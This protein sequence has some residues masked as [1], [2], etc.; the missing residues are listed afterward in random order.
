MEGAGLLKPVVGLAGRHPWWVFVGAFVVRLVLIGYGEWQDRTM[1][2]KYTDIDYMVFTDAARFITEGGSPYDRSTYRYTPL[3][4]WLMTPNIY[5]HPVFGKLLFAA[6]DVA[7]GALIY[8]L[9]PLLNDQ[10]KP[11]IAPAAGKSTTK[12]KSTTT[13][14]TKKAEAVV[15]AGQEEAIV[16]ACVWL[17]NP[18][19]IVISTRGNAE[20]LI[21]LLVVAALYCLLTKRLIL[22]AILYGLSVHFK[23]YP[24]IYALPL[25]LF[26]KYHHQRGHQQ[27]R[28][29]KKQEDTFISAFVD[30]FRITRE[31][32]VFT[33]VSGGTFVLLSL[34]LYAVY[35]FPF[36]YHTYL[37][38]IT[39]TDHR[40]NFSP[41]FY[42]LYLLSSSASS[43]QVEHTLVGDGDGSLVSTL[44]SS[45]LASSRAI[46][47]LAFLPQVVLLLSFSFRYALS[48]AARDLALC[49]FL[50]TF[51]FV[52]FLKVC[53]SQYFIWY[54]SLLPLA[55]YRSSMS[56][57][58]LVFLFALWMGTQA[59]WLS[60][61][62]Y[63]E[64]EGENTFS[65]I[66]LAS[67]AFFGANVWILIQF[68]RHHSAPV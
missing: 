51:T 49:L 66:W 41:Y 65:A 54:F 36:L 34:A 33:L 9:V 7:I 15:A 6:G 60:N 26:V 22:G 35:S 42:H 63:L 23:I 30:L 58:Q 17:F 53:T 62:Y 50:Q 14:G 52:S 40:H 18:F 28:S 37:Y 31:Q 27:K 67:L 4:A 1:V 48:G 20:S 13:K 25:V 24:I 44:A 39:R 59:M 61:A 64:F 57:L 12:P 32:V 5:L 46:G 2:V 16:W 38:H 11:T 21:G 47:L 8:L 29:G 10:A 56:L 19:S 68:I 45:L 55:L 3:L 43:P